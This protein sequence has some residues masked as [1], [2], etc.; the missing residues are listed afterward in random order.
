MMHFDAPLSLPASRTLQEVLAQCA[1]DRSIA[2]CLASATTADCT[3]NHRPL[4]RIECVA[5]EVFVHPYEIPRVSDAAAF[6]LYL[7]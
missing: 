6:I 5:V 7:P 1:Q 4:L 3:R 2:A